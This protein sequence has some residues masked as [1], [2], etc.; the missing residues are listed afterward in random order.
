MTIPQQRGRPLILHI[1]DNDAQSETLKSILEGNGFAVLQA[2]SAEEALQLCR[3]TPVSLVVAD[4]MLS[5]SSGVELAGRIKAM[6]PALPVVLHSG[7][8]P[9]SLRN[10]D[11][12]I[13]KG[14]PVT[15]VIGFLRDLV[16]RFRE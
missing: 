2:N 11:G 4:H 13:Y 9:A 12:F 10:L 1:E 7:T 6:K 8:P 3:D 5:G 14:E 15:T 16:N